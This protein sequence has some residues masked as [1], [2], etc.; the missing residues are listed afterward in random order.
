MAVLQVPVNCSGITI[1]PTSGALV[2]SIQNGKNVVTCT[3]VEITQIVGGSL[4]FDGGPGVNQDSDAAVVSSNISTGQVV[5]AI[6]AA[7]TSITI[8]GTVYPVTAGKTGNMSA[9]D[10]T[11]LLYE[12][13][14]LVIG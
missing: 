14:T 2:P 5:V 12:G 9:V 11:Q 6:S 7:I 13:F 4:L 8:N 3:A 10:A 1:A